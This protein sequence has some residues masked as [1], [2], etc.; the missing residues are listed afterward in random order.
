MTEF[1]R[2]MEEVHQLRREYEE[3]FEKSQQLY[4]EA[5]IQQKAAAIFNSAGLG[6]SAKL[7]DCAAKLGMTFAEIGELARERVLE[8]M[9]WKP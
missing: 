7:V 2:D 1:K 3:E 8:R 9:S 5:M 6:T 4:L